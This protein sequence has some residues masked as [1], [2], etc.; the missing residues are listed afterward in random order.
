[1]PIDLVIRGGQ[2]VDGSGAE[3][4]TADV[5]IA[6]DRIVEVGRVAARGAR[7]IDAVG[8]LV[9]P[10]FVDAHTHMDAQLN[11]DPLG[12]PS[13]WQGVTSV[14]MGNCGFT[15]APVRRGQ[16]ALVVRNLER[17]EDISAEAM[18]AG[19]DWRWE[20]FTEYL[21]A[22]DALPKGINYA[23]NI[24]HSA[25]RTWAM[26]A[27]AFD[28][29][30]S[31]DDLAVMEGEV[32]RAMAAGAVGFTTSRS[33]HHETSD[34]RAVASRLAS[35]DEVT[36]LVRAVGSAGGIFE[37]AQEGGAR[38]AD[39]DARADFFGRIRKLAL[40]SGAAVTFGLI[41][42]GPR[43]AWEGQ[44][45]LL[46]EVTAAGGRAVGQSHSRGV[47]ILMSFETKLPFDKLPEWREVRTRPLAEQARLLRDPEVRARLVHAANHGDYGRAVGAEARRPSWDKLRVYEQPLPPFKTLADV[48][49]A[50]GLDPV[51]CMIDLAL[52]HDLKLFFMQ[53]PDALNEADLLKI[54]R[55]PQTVMTFSDAGAHVGQILDACIQTHLLA[56]WARDKG[57]FT[58]GEAVRMVTSA[59]ARAWGFADRGL[60]KAGMIA[61]L[62]LIDLPRLDPGMPAVAGDLPA[63]AERLIMKPNGL[64][65]TL[66]AGQVLLE[67]G[68]HTGAL[69][70]RLLRR[71]PT[72]A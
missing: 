23:A 68:E 18:A 57:D 53:S 13:S 63:G 42:N 33:P 60:V 51:E 69:P 64:E 21:D 44:L 41:P 65:A 45:A 48:A 12:T 61:D 40:G 6:G 26:G 70:G 30:A 20:G 10:G 27:R 35:W 32:R 16:E 31:D 2:V 66:V 38:S 52:D 56:Y 46:E 8:L 54:M 37:I 11:W 4:V 62:N 17:A 25:L 15:L 9:T 1:M 5:A 29:A 72:A 67:R 71:T 3:P 19:I 34:N 58:I 43:E 22:I 49:Q 50:R 47:N 59:P 55:H 24:G 36:R 14:V 28:E 39:P 7:E